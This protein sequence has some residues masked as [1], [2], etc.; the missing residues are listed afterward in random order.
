MLEIIIC[1]QLVI[2]TSILAFCFLCPMM[3]QQP[4]V[5]PLHPVDGQRTHVGSPHSPTCFAPSHSP[6]CCPLLPFPFASFSSH[7]PSQPI[8]P[9][10]SSDN[11]EVPMGERQQRVPRSGVGAGPR[12]V[13]GRRRGGG[14][15][16]RL[17]TRLSEGGSERIR[18]A[19]EERGG[20]TSSPT[21]PMEPRG[22]MRR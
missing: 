22:G 5:D 12:M 21:T 8:D 6:W 19:A 13:Q 16:R 14:V 9:A 1:D 11:G 3:K 20:T 17:A 4:T 2:N 18:V 7:S 10:P 15:V